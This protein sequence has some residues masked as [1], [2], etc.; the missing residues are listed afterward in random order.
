MQLNP[1]CFKAV[2]TQHWMHPELFACQ[3]QAQLLLD[4]PAQTY[5][6]NPAFA[7]KNHCESVLR[8]LCSWLAQAPDLSLHQRVFF[9]A[10]LGLWLEVTPLQNGEVLLVSLQSDFSQEIL[11]HLPDMAL[12]LDAQNKL[13]YANASA[14]DYY[15]LDASSMQ[16]PIEKLIQSQTVRISYSQLQQELRQQQEIEELFLVLGPDGN[17]RYILSRLIRLANQSLLSLNRDMTHQKQLE[18][19]LA[20]KEETYRTLHN[21]MSDG[22]FLLGANGQILS[23]NRIAAKYFQ[24]IYGLSLQKNISIQSLNLPDMDVYL[25]AFQQA[26]Q[27]TIHQAQYQIQSSDGETLWIHCRFSPVQDEAGAIWAVAVTAHD[28]T[29]IRQARAAAQTAQ[30]RLQKLANMIPGCLYEFFLN[31]ETGE[32]GFN[33]LSKGCKELLG[34][35]AE[36][37]VQQQDLWLSLI[38]EEDLPQL[39]AQIQHSAQTMKIFETYFRVVNPQ[40]GQCWAYAR[41]TPE[42]HKNMIIWAGVLVNATET[43]TAHEQVRLREA[44]LQQS[45][46]ILESR[47]Y[48]RTRELQAAKE[49]AEAA[50]QAKS[51]FLANMSHEIRTPIHTVLGYAKLIEEH[52]EHPLLQNYLQAIRVSGNSLLTLLNDLLDLSKIEAGQ[53]SLQP[54]ALDLRRLL[55]EVKALFALK[56]SEQ[57]VQ[58]VLEISPDLPL[59][60]RLDEIRVRQILFNLIG[61]ALKFTERGQVTLS[62]NV[63]SRSAEHINLVLEVRDTGIGIPAAALQDIFEAFV[64]QAG[65]QTKKYGGTGLGLTITRRLVEMMHGKIEVHSTPEAGSSFRVCLAEVPIETDLRQSSAEGPAQLPRWPIQKTLIIADQSIQNSL[66]PFYQTH[67]LSFLACEAPEQA[68]QLLSQPSWIL[69]QLPLNGQN[70]YLTLE[71]IQQ[72]FSDTPVTVL[73]NSSPDAALL[74]QYRLQ[75]W[76]TPPL[77]AERLEQAW[78]HPAN[79]VAHFKSLP[80]QALTLKASALQSLKTE[81]M[82]QWEATFV[83]YSFDQIQAFARHLEVWSATE[84]VPGLQ[85]YALALQTAANDFDVVQ[86]ESLLS[87]FPELVHQLQAGGSP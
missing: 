59:S 84:Q 82:D 10:P 8:A 67:Q 78:L 34:Y 22:Y 18:A 80:Q 74:R 76:L 43:H 49:Q 31:L 68:A 23:F 75:S 11:A 5:C 36:E 51:D 6:V 53:M 41:S 77:D 15:Q 19:Q 61:N 71:K 33:Y 52:L 65:Q 46:Q 50:N 44:E 39:N 62:A 16:Q 70:P 57:Q 64:Q 69:L 12:L 55:Q 21:S 38:P 26:R 32:Q 42:R 54:E 79:R 30:Q 47:V 24:R 87:I 63:T 14:M 73:S 3:N 60:L 25:G 66:E 28:L 13:V 27:G 58:F 2:E 20:L 37:L 48:E 72:L 81:L 4:L 86:S 40:V 7:K 29:G 1:A 17:E 45:N 35:T 85:R 56:A 83:S 9:P